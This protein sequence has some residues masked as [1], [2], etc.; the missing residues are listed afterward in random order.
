MGPGPGDMIYP[1]ALRA[2]PDL[3]IIVLC[4]GSA[5]LPGKSDRH[6]YQR[7]AIAADACEQS[8]THSRIPAAADVGAV[9]AGATCELVGG[10]HTVNYFAVVP[11]SSSAIIRNCSRAASR[12]SVMSCAMISGAGRFADSSKA[13]SF[14]QKMSRFTLSRFVSSS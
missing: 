9:A 6:V 12:S 14:S 3:R 13:S 4:S 2:A 10:S 1:T 5:V 7:A 11:F 8:D